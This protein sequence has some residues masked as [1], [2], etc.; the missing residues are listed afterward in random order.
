KVTLTIDSPMLSL[1]DV[2]FEN[3][4]FGSL[5]SKLSQDIDTG[6]VKYERL[7]N[8]VWKTLT[9]VDLGISRS[10]FSVKEN[11]LFATGRVFDLGKDI[12]LYA[13]NGDE[14]VTIDGKTTQIIINPAYQLRLETRM[15]FESYYPTV[16]IFDK[17]DN[18]VIFIIQLQAK[19]LAGLNPLQILDNQY[20]LQPLSG[21]VYGPFDGGSCLKKTYGDCELYIGSQGSLYVP[22]P[23][24]TQ[25]HG[26]YGY[27][28]NS[29]LYRITNLGGSQVLSI[30]FDAKSLVGSGN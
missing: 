25:Y 10:L 6:S 18:K 27:Q 28:N 17:I 29:T 24:H 3:G 1:T 4:E 23:Y 15:S 12:V 2:N 20:S 19:N 22:A 30:T 21:Q 14:M 8:G 26:T 7:R 11:Q 5:V 9:G 13:Q 16:Q